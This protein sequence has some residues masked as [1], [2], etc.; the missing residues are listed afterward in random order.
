MRVDMSA[1]AVTTRLQRASQLRRLCLSLG[2]ATAANSGDGRT[3]TSQVKN[4][5]KSS[6]RE[7]LIATG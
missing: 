4:A 2:Q 1:K 3:N 7:G 6:E 5:K